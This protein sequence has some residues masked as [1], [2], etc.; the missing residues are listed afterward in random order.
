MVGVVETFGEWLLR[1]F[2]KTQ[3]RIT[4]NGLAP[5]TIPG[6]RAPSVGKPRRH[7]VAA[8]APIGHVATCTGCRSIGSIQ[9]ATLSQDGRA[10]VE[11]RRWAEAA[12]RHRSGRPL[13]LKAPRSIARAGAHHRLS[14]DG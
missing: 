2:F 12:C 13:A 5:S 9:A 11:P 8:G 1:H 3:A 4:A 14:R 10:G 6:V 7:S